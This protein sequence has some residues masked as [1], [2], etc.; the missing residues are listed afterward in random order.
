MK[1]RCDDGFLVLLTF[2]GFKPFFESE[3]ESGKDNIIYD[4]IVKMHHNNDSRFVCAWV[5][6]AQSW[7]PYKNNIWKIEPKKKKKE[8]N[9]ASNNDHF[10]VWF[11]LISI[12]MLNTLLV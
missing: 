11:R 9:N 1:L 6:M 10:H 3:R 4:E 7:Q 2:N 8:E 5:K 12:I